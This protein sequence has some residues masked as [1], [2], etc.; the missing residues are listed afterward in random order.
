MAFKTKR[1][2][3]KIF[4][5]VI[6]YLSTSIDRFVLLISVLMLLITGY[7]MWDNA[8]V[9]KLASAEEF[10]Q[11]KPVNEK[12]LSFGE[13]KK[14]NS[15]VIGWIEVYGTE[16]D[17]PIVQTTDNS[18]YLNTTVDGKFSTAGSIFLDFRNNPNFTDFSN[19]IYGH[20]MAERK[21]FGDL[22]KFVEKEFFDTHKYAVIKRDGLS[23]LGIEL[24]AI[25]KTHGT[26]EIIFN[27]KINDPKS[28][29]SL[30][31]YLYQNSIYNRDV[32]LTL[33]DNIVLLDTCTFTITNGRYILAGKLTDKAVKNPFPPEK[34]ENKFIDFTKNIPKKPVLFLILL[35][36]LMI[37][38]LYR[39]Y[40]AYSE[41]EKR[42][43]LDMEAFDENE[44]N[45]N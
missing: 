17:Y 16:I 30:I 15:D 31:D 6:S 43:K 45:E 33:E 34:S 4:L 38:I 23:D 8:Q 21:M 36:L 18:Q 26:D 27:N 12:E 24:F 39:L 10:S 14:I 7:S 5:K 44:N 28:K 19:I 1:E 25:I 9:Y 3:K 37:A 29:N 42:E 11:Y 40:V 2:K 35:L 20:H 22:D 32:N 41:K 13:L